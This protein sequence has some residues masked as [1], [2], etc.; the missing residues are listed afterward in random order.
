MVARSRALDWFGYE[1]QL[2]LPTF[3]FHQRYHDL[4][5]VVLEAFY[6]GNMA[7]ILQPVRA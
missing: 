6:C 7:E 2:I 1:I 4:D 3:T 5:R